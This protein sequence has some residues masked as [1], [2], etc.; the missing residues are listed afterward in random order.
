MYEWQ[1]CLRDHRWSTNK[2]HVSAS[3][4]LFTSTNAL[5][6]VHSLFKDVTIQHGSILGSVYLQLLKTETSICL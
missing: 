3:M 5:I 4:V 2:I 1:K 6:W